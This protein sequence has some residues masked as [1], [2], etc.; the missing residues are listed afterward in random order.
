MSK[1]EEG[2]ALLEMEA[3]TGERGCHQICKGRERE[4][5]GLLGEFKRKRKLKGILVFLL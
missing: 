5:G 2:L 1:R 4:I 3:V